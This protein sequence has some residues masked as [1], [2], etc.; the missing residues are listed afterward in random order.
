MKTISKREKQI[1]IAIRNIKESVYL[2]AIKKYL[3]KIMRTDW[4]I[5]AIHKP[6]MKLEEE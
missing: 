6:L 1:L 4:S 2:L 5:A 3:S